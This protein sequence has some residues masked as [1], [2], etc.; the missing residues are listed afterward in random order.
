[1]PAIKFRLLCAVLLFAV[2]NSQALTLGRLRGAALVGQ[3]LDVSIPILGDAGDGA[4]GLCVEADVFHADARQEPSRV[5]VTVE[6]TQ[7]AQAFSVR[8]VSSSVIDEPVVTVYLRAGCGQKTSRRYVLLADV[9]TEQAAAPVARVAQVPLIVPAAA[10][11][12]TQ[13]ASIKRST[14]VGSGPGAITRK[15]R[16]SSASRS[17]S[18]GAADRAAGM[19]AVAKRP[20]AIASARKAARPKVSARAIASTPADEK[21]LAGRSAGQSRLKLDPIEVLA[22]RVAT[23]E[24]ST[25]GAPADLVAREARDAQRLQAL[26]ASV[27]NLLVAASRNEASLLDLKGRLQQAESERYSNPIVYGLMAL[28]LASLAGIALLLAR[29]RRQV[30]GS[31]ANWWGGMEQQ[32]PK[33]AAAQAAP[34]ASRPSG[35]TPA[36]ARAALSGPDSLTQVDA[37]PHP[38]A[39]RAGP[40]SVAGPVTQADVS[41][42][43]M[44][45]STFDRLMQSG[46]SHSAVRK[47]RVPEPGQPVSGAGGKLKSP[48]ESIDV[49]QQA[50]FF[51]SLGQTDEAVRVLENRIGQSGESSPLAYLD[52]LKIFHSLGLR[53]DFRQV[54]EDFGLLFNARVP[55]F[56]GFADE[57]KGLEEYPDVIASLVDVWG[58]PGV[59]AMI[60]NCVFRDQRH[61]PSGLLD[62]AAFRDLLLLHAVALAVNAP[63]STPATMA[64]SVPHRL[65]TARSGAV[66][67][68]GVGARPPGIA[69]NLSGVSAD[70]PLP[71]IDGEPELDIDL[72]DLHISMSMPLAA[73]SVDIELESSSDAGN[74]IDFDL[75]DPRP[76]D[77][78]H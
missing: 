31:G 5:Q 40:R 9:L 20:A 24:S 47:P 13:E 1:M 45:E 75:P 33:S 73:A 57:G 17:R 3:G 66:G 52:L 16:A 41:L 32:V 76:K 30:R 36:S 74:M 6:P 11:D 25:A 12:R 28:L 60:E 54:R 7:S 44:S 70:V 72:S 2:S 8:I 51:V 15:A 39:R 68:P 22:E 26:E 18:G 46:V 53:D 63:D 49:R 23:L 61:A 69:R 67:G 71:T 50:E 42:V 38:P 55:E 43:E 27:K 14:G 10:A 77:A 62:L 34:G 4:A 37:P 65:A 35:F 48:D 58:T 29:G 56:S 21:L 64:A 19:P 78:A 59:F